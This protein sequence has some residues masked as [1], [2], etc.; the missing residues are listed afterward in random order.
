M[1]GEGQESREKLSKIINISVV[2]VFSGMLALI[3]LPEGKRN[4]GRKGLV[5]AE[6]G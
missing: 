4:D 2:I 5:W 3:N 6:E 1:N